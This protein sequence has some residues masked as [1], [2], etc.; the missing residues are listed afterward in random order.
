MSGRTASVGCYII[1]RSFVASPRLLRVN[2]GPCRSMPPRRAS[3]FSRSFA[4]RP[5]QE[6]TV[7]GTSRVGH[8][9]AALDLGLRTQE[10]RHE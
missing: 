6:V 4:G 8:P 5:H 2:P 7:P 3:F 9:Q 1:P 10:E